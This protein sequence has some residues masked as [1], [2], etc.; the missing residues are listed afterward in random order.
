MHVKAEHISK[1]FDEKLAVANFSFEARA[2]FIT[3]ILGDSEAG[4]TTILRMLLGIVKPDEGYISFDDNILNQKILDTIGYLPEERGVYQQHTLN[5]IL[6]YFARL[7][8]LPRKKAQVEAVRLMDRFNLIEQMETPVQILPEDVRQ[9]VELMITLIHNP[10][11]IIFD[12]PFVNM[13]AENQTLIR[14]MVQRLREDGKTIILATG[15][16]EEAELLCDEVILLHQGETLMKGKVNDLLG[17]FKYNIIEVEG[18]DNLQPLKQLS[19]VKKMTQKKQVAQLF[20]D[21]EVSP[22]KILDEIIRTV[23]VSRIEIKRPGL[24]DIYLDAVQKY[25]QAAL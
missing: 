2:G 14:K 4:K 11:L 10:D 13:A 8:N 21:K 16:I 9:K 5:E 15:K 25:R 1:S 22:Q 24:R 7:K 20:V 3:G 6:V 12:E 18:E 17:K 19:G 23:N